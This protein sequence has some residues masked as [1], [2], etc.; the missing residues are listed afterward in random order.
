MNGTGFPGAGPP[1]PGVIPAFDNP[2]SIGYRLVIVASVF[3][4]VTGLFLFLRLY[5]AAFILRKWHIDDCAFT[6]STQLLCGR[7]N[8]QC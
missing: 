7:I 3:P 4:A 5:T 1:P 8:K 6:L 2:E